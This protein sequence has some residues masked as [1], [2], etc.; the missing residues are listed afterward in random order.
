MFPSQS[1]TFSVPVCFRS[2]CRRSSSPQY[3]GPPWSDPPDERPPLSNR[4]RI[5]QSGDH[6]TRN[7]LHD[8]LRSS[9]LEPAL[10]SVVDRHRKLPLRRAAVGF[11]RPRQ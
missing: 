3:L 2:H 11:R 8:L 10:D 9:V 5:L 6:P 7:G 4:T 1:R